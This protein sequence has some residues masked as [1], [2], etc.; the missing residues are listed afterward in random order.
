SLDEAPTEAATATSARSARDLF[1]MRAAV[2]SLNA[3]LLWYPTVFSWFP[4]PRGQRNLVGIHDCI[5]E[6]FP[7]ACF[8]NRRARWLWTIKVR[9][10]IRRA[11]RFMTISEMSARDLEAVY[12]IPRSK[13]TVTTLAAGESFRPAT[14]AEQE[15]ARRDSGLKA[16]DRWFVYL[17]GLNPHKR[18]D[19]ILQAM[20]ADGLEPCHLVLVGSW[21]GDRF[22]GAQSELQDFV[23]QSGLADRVH[24][25]GRRSDDELRPLL[26]GARAL[27]LPSMCEG[28]GL[29]AVEAAA[30]GSPVIATTESPL[31]ELLDGGGLFVK[32]GDLEA[33][34]T[35]M[36]RLGTDDALHRLMST[37]A[38]DRASRLTWQDAARSTLEAIE[39]CA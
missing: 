32:P 21:D 24:W 37:A 38:R 31:P 10:A 34:T 35:A 15:A 16:G 18:V 23:D 17:G 3:D 19:L 5:A 2:R 7:D 11:T 36:R 25:L 9:W 20:A 26:S 27:L 30:C 12:A 6:R 22:H 28:F 8:S 13:V 1:R 29:P 4:P 14:P 33:L 39:A